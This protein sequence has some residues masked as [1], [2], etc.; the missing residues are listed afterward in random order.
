MFSS[1]LLLMCAPC[2]CGCCAMLVCGCW[3]VEGNMHCL[4]SKGFAQGPGEEGVAHGQ[5][6]E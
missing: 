2:T 3:H 4:D 1:V 6:Q 5:S